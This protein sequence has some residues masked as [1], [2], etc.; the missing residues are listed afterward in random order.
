MRIR[1]P[2]V[3][4]A[5]TLTASAQLAEK[6]L[7]RAASQ[8]AASITGD[9]SFSKSKINIGFNG[10]P[11]TPARELKPAEIS[12]LY[13]VAADTAGTGQLYRISI[14]GTLR[15]LNR[16]TLCGTADIHWLTTYMSGKVLK[17]TFFS[18]EEAPTLTFEAVQ[19][20]TD[21]CGTFTYVR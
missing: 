16:N 19:N 3:L 18:S 15:L 6:G 20:S 11:L 4:L 21:V 9:I 7:W 13:D 14:P 5:L 1:L 12:A 8:N 2:L 17:L 10:F